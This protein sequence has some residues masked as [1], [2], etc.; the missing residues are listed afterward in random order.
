M[1]LR[2]KTIDF[3]TISSQ[4]ILQL[5]LFF[6]TRTS[7]I[8]GMDLFQMVY[9]LCNAHPTPF[10]QQLYLKISEFLTRQCQLVTSRITQPTDNLIGL[11]LTEWDQYSIASAYAN[12][13][14]YN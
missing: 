13:I 10:A 12:M 14:W 9:D 1:S 7:S 2:P 8:K 5:E 6:S 4:F 11:Y 3:E